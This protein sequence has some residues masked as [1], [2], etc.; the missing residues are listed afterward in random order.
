[1]VDK[2]TTVSRRRLGACIGKLG[3]NDLQRLHQA[4]VV[5]LGLA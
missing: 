3:R 5:F 1:M 4:A 2:I